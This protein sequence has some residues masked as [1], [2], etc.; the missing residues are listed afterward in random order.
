VSSVF[1]AANSL[2]LL[3]LKF[4]TKFAIAFSKYTH[5]YISPI[6]FLRVCGIETAQFRLISVTLCESV[7]FPFPEMWFCFVRL[8]FLCWALCCLLLPS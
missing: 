5:I 3:S 6:N 1:K 7:R 2:M 4:S 8:H